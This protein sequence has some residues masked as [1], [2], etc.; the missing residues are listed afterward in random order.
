MHTQKTDTAPRVF[1]GTYA[2]YSA[3]RLRGFWVDLEDFAG[4]RPAFLE[5]CR[6]LHNDE[7]EPELM[8]PDYEGFPAEYYGESEMPERLF[9]WLELDEDDRQLLAAYMDATSDTRADIR[10]ARDHYAGTYDSGA[11]FAEAM[12]EEWGCIPKDLPAWISIDWEHS[13]EGGLRFD[14]S[15]SEHNGDTW[16]FHN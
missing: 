16:F 1:V 13:W 12:A 5:H 8:F 7:H 6:E 11:E 14:Y 4:D 15:T 9:E 2:K 3:G 10:D